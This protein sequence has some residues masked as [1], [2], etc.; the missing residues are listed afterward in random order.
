MYDRIKVELE[1]VKQALQSSH[2]VSTTP[3]PS[4]EQDLG[5]ELAQLHRL[6]DATKTHLHCA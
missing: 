3:L 1:G 2:A 4:K 5:D 6:V